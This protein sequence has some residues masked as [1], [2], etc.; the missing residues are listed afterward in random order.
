MAG[1]YIQDHD[2]ISYEDLKHAI[3]DA[4][5]RETSADPD[6]WDEDNPAYGQCAVTALVVQDMM[7]GDI[8]WRDA[9]VDK[10]GDLEDYFEE[11]EHVSHY[12]N[13]IDGE[14]VDLTQQQF[15]EATE[16]RQD[17]DAVDAKLEQDDGDDFDTLR[18]YVLSYDPTRERYATLKAD[19]FENLA[20][21]R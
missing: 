21:K 18:D 7:G 3:E 20:A 17:E 13:Q 11:D 4:W 5:Q 8:V 9:V 19:V 6:G 14:T 1:A 16:Y 12:F 10:P 15:P 2:E